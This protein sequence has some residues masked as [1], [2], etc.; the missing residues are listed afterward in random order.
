MKA[1]QLTAYGSD[2]LQVNDAPKPTPQTG[3]VLVE[4]YAAAVNPFDWKVRDGHMKE[5]IPLQL[6]ATLGGDLAGVISEVG[7]GVEDFSL[8][9]KVYG[10]ANAVGGQGSLAEFAPVGIDQLA[11]MPAG[12][13]FAQ[14]AA[15]PLV[16][17]SAYQALVEH[18]NLQPGQ[19]ILI[20]GAAGGIG[21]MAVQIAKQLNAYVAATASANDVDFVKQLGAN[22]VIHY[23][24]QDF[25]K[26]IKGYD[27]VFDTVGGDTNTKSY[28][29]LKP[30]G[31]LVSM[32]TPEDEPLAKQYQIRYVQ[33]S[34][35]ATS[36]RLQAV[37]KLVEAGNL[38]VNV[39][40][41]FPLDQAPQAFEYL[42][43]GH[44]RGKVV[45]QVK[46]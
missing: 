23:K 34:S 27:A 32:T 29:V 35:Q 9:Q 17:T 43:T 15:L 4:V 44:P 22:E 26:I 42:K 39:D 33:Q 14:A 38:K 3:Q 41:I 25:T 8:G 28:A 19:K 16:A 12:I 40:K 30:G 18:M 20:H 36:E 37:S 31:I 45:I 1:A 46:V 11:P 10:S 7:E 2:G 13:E 21:S 6:P 5:F 24:A